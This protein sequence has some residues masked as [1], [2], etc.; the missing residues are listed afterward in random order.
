MLEGI[1]LSRISVRIDSNN[2]VAHSG[3]IAKKKAEDIVLAGVSGKFGRYVFLGKENLAES[4]AGGLFVLDSDLPKWITNGLRQ[5]INPAAIW[6]NDYFAAISVNRPFVLATFDGELKDTRWRGDVSSNGE[7]FLRFFGQ[8]WSQESIELNQNIMRLLVHELVH[9]ENGVR[10]RKSEGEPEWL[11]EGL[12]EYVAMLY[13]TARKSPNDIESFHDAVGK[14]G[15]QCISNLAWKHVGISDHSMQHGDFPYN[16][17]ILAFWIVDGG[18]SN[19]DY[20][21]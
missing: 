10:F 9:L 14:H 11:S 19:L 3:F 1:E 8:G 5:A 18:A 20:G 4:L 2:V 12:A 6:L 15:S 17:G 7:I 13:T 21:N 16:C